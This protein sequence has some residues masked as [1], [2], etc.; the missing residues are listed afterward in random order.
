MARSTFSAATG[1]TGRRS[2][3]ATARGTRPP[4]WGGSAPGGGGEAPR[5]RRRPGSGGGIPPQQCPAP[6]P[7]R[8]GGVGKKKKKSKKK[9]QKANNNS[10]QHR[11]RY[12]ASPPLFP[13][14]PSRAG[15]EGEGKAPPRGLHRGRVPH[16][17]NEVEAEEQVLDALGASFDGHG[18]GGGQAGVRQQG[19]WRP[20]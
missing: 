7:L 15:G 18:G 11:S 12:F 4:R 9:R 1:I 20:G 19:R 5:C 10:P 2:P 17:E 13:W 3:S 16:P 8:R 14:A 6:T